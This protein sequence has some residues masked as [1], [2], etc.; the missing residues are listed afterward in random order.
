[1][2]NAIISFA[3]PASTFSEDPLTDV[4]RQGARKL[5][6]AALIAEIEEYA[7]MFVGQRTPSGGLAVRRN[8]YCR[9]RSISTGIGPITIRQPR[10]RD[11][12]PEI[13][14]ASGVFASKILPP[15]LR[16]TKSIED[17]VPW[18]YLKGISTGDISEALAALLGPDAPGLS[19]GTVVR[20]KSIWA[21]EF[22]SWNNR[23]L[24]NKKYVY[25]WV[26]GIHF[27]VRLTDDRPCILVVIG[28]RA[29]GRKD[30]LAL[31]SGARE[32]EMSWR[33]VLENLKRR[34]LTEAPK[35]AVGDGALGFWKALPQ[36]FPST[37]AQR[38]WCHKTANILNYLPKTLHAAAKRDIQA[39]WMASTRKNAN[40]ALASFR[41]TYAAKYPKAVH[42]LDKDHDELFTF[43]DF[44]A[45][46]WRHLRTTN[47][48]ES[49]FATVRLRT[50]RTKGCGSVEATVIMAFK[51]CMCA[52]KKWRRLNAVERLAE[53][54]Q[55]VK[56][57]DGERK[58]A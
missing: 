32:S 57:E 40:A 26:D 11:E 37:R 35:V 18:L 23:S 34:G 45:E 33:H 47:P 49:T 58:A 3:Q 16:K 14:K 27:N 41:K 25:I 42:C 48:I 51:L 39:I 10:I 7:S 17:L 50:K 1:M 4:L 56:F 13:E 19:A 29:D 12:R 44:P 21:K 55:L 54:I 2:K 9:E 52:E 31:E 43:Y 30:L 28:A 5:L 46:H 15:Y 20:L 38:C 36:V 53:V 22:E 24:A 6:H 8:G